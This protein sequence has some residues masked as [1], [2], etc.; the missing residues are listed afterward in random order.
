MSAA[1]RIFALALIIAAAL[2]PLLFAPA[3]AALHDRGGGLIYDDLLDITWL[4]DANYAMSSGYRPDGRLNWHEANE[5]AAGLDYGGFDDWRLPTVSPGDPPYTF[6]NNGTAAI[7]TGA[8]GAGWGPVG[9][10]DGIWSE[11]G[12]MTYHNLGNLGM[13]I[14]ND[15]DPQAQVE[16]P[17]WGLVNVGL[18]VNLDHGDDIHVYWTGTADETGL[19]NYS[20]SYEVDK[21]LQQTHGNGSRFFAWAVRDGDVTQPVPEPGTLVLLAVGVAG[22]AAARLRAARRP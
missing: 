22:L 2:Q 9:D 10:P 6:S 19:G 20:W 4:Q 17:G 14:P 3:Q 16:Q 15:Q 5:W 12:W 1:T 13:Y 7:G 11:L 18:F 21:G 8:T